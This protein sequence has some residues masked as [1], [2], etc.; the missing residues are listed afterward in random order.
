M[1]TG[2]TSPNARAI[3]AAT[4]AP[5]VK[6]LDV[7]QAVDFYTKG[8]ELAHSATTNDEYIKA[9][10]LFSIAIAIRSDQSRFFFARANAFRAINEFEYALK[11]Y[12]LAITID[13]RLPL[14]YANRGACYRKLNQPIQAL[15]DLTAAIEMDIKK[16][17]HYFNRALVL[18]EGSYYKEA[19][20]DFTKT[21]EDG[22]GGI[23]MEYRVLQSRSNCY[24]K[25]GLLRKLR[26]YV[27]VL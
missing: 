13:D 27:Q 25:L 23:R 1:T 18:Y 15:E 6:S 26:T 24:R 22:N 7:L 8:T 10:E 17:N 12:T 19:I 20:L 9:I 11:D 3:S 4:H 5:D 21:L 14:Y 2:S 16:A